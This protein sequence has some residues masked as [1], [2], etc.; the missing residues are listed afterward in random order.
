MENVP[1]G[2]TKCVCVCVWVYVLKRNYMLKIYWKN[3]GKKRCAPKWFF[4]QWDRP[5]IT[6]TNAHTHTHTLAYTEHHHHHHHWAIII[7]WS[8][9]RQNNIIIIGKENSLFFPYF[10]N[11]FFVLSILPASTGAP[12]TVFN[13]QYINQS[14]IECGL[15]L[16]PN[17]CPQTRQTDDHSSGFRVFKLEFFYLFVCLFFLVLF[18]SGFYICDWISES[19]CLI[20]LFPVY[21][22]IKF[23]ANL[24]MYKVGF[25]NNSFFVVV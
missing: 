6:I 15:F 21:F 9:S 2:C 25:I 1:N 23:S 10:F 8:I 12:I 16:F 5:H 13:S 3:V 14:R 22:F 11:F 17:I 20:L 4:E 24:N 18:F 7:F 19:W